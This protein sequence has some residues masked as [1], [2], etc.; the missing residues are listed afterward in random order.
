MTESYDPS[1]DKKCEE[2][3]KLREALTDM[4][5]LLDE[6]ILVRD[7]SHDHEDDW[8]LSMVPFIQRLAKNKEALDV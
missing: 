7:I 4:F 5:A 6:G 8:A 2:A 3:D 1:Y